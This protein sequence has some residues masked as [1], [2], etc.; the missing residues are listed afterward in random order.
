MD[1]E[2]AK[3]IIGGE[4]VAIAALAGYIV[5]LHADIRGLLKERLQS[6]E[7]KLKLLEMLGGGNSGNATGGNP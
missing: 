5:K 3:W 2:L 4:A 1:V 6:A 7:E